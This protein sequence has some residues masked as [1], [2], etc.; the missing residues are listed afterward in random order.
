MRMGQQGTVKIVGSTIKNA[1]TM[2]YKSEGCEYMSN[3]QNYCNA[4][5][6]LLRLGLS[7]GVQKLHNR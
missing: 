6:V 1:C 3:R 7:E 5:L 2:G 4:S